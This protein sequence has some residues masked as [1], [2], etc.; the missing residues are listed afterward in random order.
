MQCDEMT[1]LLRERDRERSKS[2]R[3]RE[4]GKQE[5]VGKRE[6]E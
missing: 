6:I 4:L 1:D 5:W 2:G 3:D